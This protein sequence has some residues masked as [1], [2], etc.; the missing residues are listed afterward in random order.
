MLSLKQRVIAV[1]SG[2]QQSV[3][4]QAIDE[5]KRSF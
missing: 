4:Y 2:M 1:Q 3:D 5:Q